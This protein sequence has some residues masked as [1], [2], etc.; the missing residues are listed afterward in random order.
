M[1]SIPTLFFPS[2]KHQNILPLTQQQ[3]AN[4]TLQ[5]SH[6]HFNVNNIQICMYNILPPHPAHIQVNLLKAMHV[7][8]VS[9][10]WL[11]DR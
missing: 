5:H 7:P 11:N 3:P 4:I 6:C 1:L 8:A 9:F 10:H 2:L